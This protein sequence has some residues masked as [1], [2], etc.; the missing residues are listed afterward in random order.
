MYELKNKNQTLSIF[1]VSDVHVGSPNFNQ[2]FYEYMLTKFKQTSGEKIIYLLG[3]LMDCNTKRIGNSAYHQELTPNE[4]L[5]YIAK[6]L[7]PY[8]KYI[9]GCVP[10]NH[11]NRYKKE[12]DLDLTQIL[13]EQLDIEYNPAEVYDTL[14]INDREYNIYGVHGTKTSQQQ[15]LMQGNVQRQTSHINS[16]LY[17]YGHSHYLGNWSSVERHGDKYSRKNY[18]LTGHY[19]NYDGSY[20]Q[21]QLLKPNLPGF[22]KVSIDRNLRTGVDLYNVDEVMI[23]E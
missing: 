6:S 4:Q 5:N 1:P 20:A 17:L 9:K 18:V 7:Q 22:C 23:Y 11:E 15:H 16:N 21:E 8:K 13:A 3:D 14:L 12:F 19:L 2:E 10:G